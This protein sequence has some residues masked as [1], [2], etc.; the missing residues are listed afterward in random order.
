MKIQENNQTTGYDLGRRAQLQNYLRRKIVQMGMIHNFLIYIL[1]L[2][3]LD[4]PFKQ[5]RSNNTYKLPLAKGMME[6]E[7]F[8]KICISQ[9]HA[10]CPT[11]SMGCCAT[12]YQVANNFSDGSFSI[13]MAEGGWY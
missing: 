7:P 3:I 11:A 13:H 5:A 6:I 12:F 9:A 2:F 4:S 10:A 8:L 1:H